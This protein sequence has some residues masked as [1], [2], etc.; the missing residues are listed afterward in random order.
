MLEV[1]QAYNDKCGLDE[2]NIMGDYIDMYWVNLHPKLPDHFTVKGTFKDEIQ[3]AC[4]ELSRLRSLFPKARIR[5]IEGNHEYRLPRYLTAKA[6]ELFDIVSIKELLQLDKHGIV[7]VPSGK[8]QIVPCL[9]TAYYLRHK[10]FSM[11]KHCARATLDKKMTSLGFGHTHR[12]QC[13]TTTDALGKELYGRSLGWL[14]DRLAPVF[15]FMDCDEWSQGFEFVVSEKR[16]PHH[17][18]V[19]VRTIEATR[20]AV[21]DGHLYSLP[22]QKPY[23]GNYTKTQSVSSRSI[24]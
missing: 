19:D 17:Q 16:V 24:A 8:T 9:D 14:G 2:I 3:I 5:Y 18:Y 11:S 12:K 22:Y 6:P 23:D 13:A 20:S 15:S 10:P 7:Y 21:F 1:A 4:H